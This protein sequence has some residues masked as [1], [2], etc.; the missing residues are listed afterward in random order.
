MEAKLKI[1]ED[2]SVVGWD[3]VYYS[4]F[5][6]PPLTTI[7]TST[8]LMAKAFIK[9]ITRQLNEENVPLVETLKVNL[10]IRDSVCERVEI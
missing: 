8:S 2:I 5:M 4:A 3:N 9:N 7:N 10:V 1:P 6:S